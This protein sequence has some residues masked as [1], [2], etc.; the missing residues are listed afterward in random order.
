[1]LRCIPNPQLTF[2][3]AKR[4]ETWKWKDEKLL[5]NWNENK[6]KEEKS[7]AVNKKGWEGWKERSITEAW[8]PLRTAMGSGGGLF[9]LILPSLST[10]S[11]TKNLSL[12]SPNSDARFRRSFSRFLLDGEELRL[13]FGFSQVTIFE[14]STQN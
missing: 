5:Y 6:G 11:A 1:M 9:L 8:W 10:K 7:Y 14:A 12:R 3:R 13:R 2:C 4:R